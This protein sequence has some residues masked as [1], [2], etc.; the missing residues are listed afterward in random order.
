MRQY[1]AAPCSPSRFVGVIE[2]RVV[3]EGD[4]Q[5]KARV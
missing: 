3:A 4:P 2:M 5:E 1:G